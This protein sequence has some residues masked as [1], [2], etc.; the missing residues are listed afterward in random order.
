MFKNKIAKKLST[1]FFS[2]SICHKNTSFFGNNII[3]LQTSTSMR[4]I[5]REITLV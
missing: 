2:I 3:K 1:S 4:L 5:Q